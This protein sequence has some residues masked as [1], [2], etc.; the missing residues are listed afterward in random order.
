VTL[1]LFAVCR[2]TEVMFRPS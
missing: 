1:L 2:K